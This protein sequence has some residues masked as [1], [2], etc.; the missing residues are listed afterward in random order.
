MSEDSNPNLDQIL[1]E[2]TETVD[3]N[4]PEPEAEGSAEQP[5]GNP[6]AQP[7]PETGDK[8]DQDGTPPPEG[9][10]KDKKPD[11]DPQEAFKKAAIDERRKRQAYEQ[12]LAQMRQEIQKLKQGEQ[13]A[14]DIFEDPEG[15][16]RWQNEQVS[17]Q[18]GA[19]KLNMSEALVRE[20]VG[21]EA[22]ESAMEYFKDEVARNPSIVQELNAH[23]NPAKFAYHVG[24]QAK[25]RAEIGD[26]REYAKRAVQQALAERDKGLDEIVKARV[27][28]ML[29]E[30][31]PKSLANAQSAGSRNQAPVD[32][33]HLPLSAI[34]GEK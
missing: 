33:G 31:L 16:Q 15:Y 32:E 6:E 7:K 28:A 3:L 34:L 27:E 8:Q 29:A 4:P 30:R 22:F 14:P 12:E 2:T 1:N 13:K 5:K 9:A 18:L 20:S 24:L 19:M 23:P 10:D 17:S 21:D 11:A 25:D 26:P